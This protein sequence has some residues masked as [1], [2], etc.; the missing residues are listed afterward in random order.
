MP[1]KAKPVQVRLLAKLDTT[2]GPDSC[3][4]WQGCKNRHG[5]GLSYLM[6]NGKRKTITAH[7]AV[8]MVMRGVTLA[9]DVFLLHSCDNPPCCNPTHLRPGTH[10]ENM[11]DR[12]TRGAGYPTGLDNHRAMPVSDETVAAVRAEY[13]WHTQGRGAP[14][15]A[16]KY[17][18]SR[19]VVEHIV[20]RI[21]RWKESA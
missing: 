7:R 16:A 14:A 18:L 2:G 12:K 4:E 10:L 5:Y 8:Y 21:G 20:N 19:A 15:L 11:H 1:P 13:K 17:G 3:W 9:P 6:V